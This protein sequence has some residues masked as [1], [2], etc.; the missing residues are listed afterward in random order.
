MARGGSNQMLSVQQ[1]AENLGLSSCT[2]YRQW[3]K[4]GLKGYRVGR[5]LKFREREIESW[6]ESR[7]A[8][9]EQ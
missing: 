5:Q 6:L 1:T 2:L 7:V 3:R 4:W 9:K 8:D